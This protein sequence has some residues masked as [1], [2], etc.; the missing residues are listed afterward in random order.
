MLK[1]DQHSL[2]SK[3][4]IGLDQYFDNMTMLYQS[5]M[6]P[7][8]LL[9][10]G[11]KGIGKFTLVFHFLNYVYSHNE[12][13]FYNINKK[14]IN[15]KSVFYNSILNKT[16][17]DI[18]FFQAKEGKNIKIEDVRNL[19]SFLSRS[20]LSNN[21]RFTVIDDVEYL[22]VNSANALLKTLEEPSENNYFILINNQ[23]AV[24]ME[25][26]SSRCLKNN[27]FLNSTQSKKIT[28]HL[29][30]NKKFNLFTDDFNNLTP[31][32]IIKY[33]ELFNRYK[34][35]NDDYIL[36]KL[37]KL[38]YAYKKDKDKDLIGLSFFYID[39][40]FYSLVEK[41]ANKIDF[42]LNLKKNIINKI[43]DFT[44]YNLNISSVLNSIELK[45]KNVE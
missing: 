28:E 3:K 11:K 25:T 5:N 31:G 36:L 24:M 12:K 41:N 35:I 6:F 18:I 9:L 30:E 45:L 34:I 39:Q 19:K 40:F 13:T 22:N 15:S 23:Q 4:L 32:L 27:I 26:I 14:I 42:F 10:N 16:C 20:S 33:N 44:V 21:P 37:S 43:N 29:L 2:I 38:L 17:L 8:I 7:K 1:I